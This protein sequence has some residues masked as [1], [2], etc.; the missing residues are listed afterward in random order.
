MPKIKISALSRT[1]KVN[2]LRGIIAVARPCGFELGLP[3]LSCKCSPTL[4][5]SSCWS[6]E[7]HL[8]GPSSQAFVVIN[9]QHISL[10]NCNSVCWSSEYQ[11]RPAHGM[12]YRLARAKI[13]MI[14][15][16]GACRAI[17]CGARH[18]AWPSLLLPRDFFLSQIVIVARRKKLR[19]SGIGRGTNKNY[20]TAFLIC[21]VL[22]QLLL[23]RGTCTF[24][25]CR[26]D[27][28]VKTMWRL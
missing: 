20:F 27:F 25:E 16:S 24:A 6:P 15:V 17:L 26:S 23:Q 4:S 7:T 3:S 12:G 11:S 10:A 22:R 5:F 1:Q 14:D 2:L 19:P 21:S 28:H 13:H 18:V 8:A 9:L